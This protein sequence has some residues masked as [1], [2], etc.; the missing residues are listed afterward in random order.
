MKTCSCRYYLAYN[1]CHHKYKA[2]EIY[3][4][5][6]RSCKFT[7]RERRGAKSKLEKNRLAA[8]AKEKSPLETEPTGLFNNWP[9]QKIQ[10]NMQLNA[11][12]NFLYITESKNCLS[13]Y[14]HSSLL[15]VA[16]LFETQQGKF[17][18]NKLLSS[19]SQI[20]DSIHPQEFVPTPQVISVEQP[21]HEQQ[22]AI[23]GSN[24]LFQSQMK[25]ISNEFKVVKMDRGTVLSQMNL[26]NDAAPI[27]MP[28]KL[29]VNLNDNEN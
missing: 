15:S 21:A 11:Y 10:L 9:L 8:V 6:D 1:S 3:D 20:P 18:W 19:I 4:I 13:L 12:F 17:E 25:A 23:Q 24:L 29:L 22:N 27:Q 14:N 5:Q 26:N 2:F 28:L 16:S 7:F